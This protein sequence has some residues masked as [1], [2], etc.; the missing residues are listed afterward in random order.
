M[1]TTL[2]HWQPLEVIKCLKKQ[3]WLGSYFTWETQLSW[4]FSCTCFLLNFTKLQHINPLLS[5]CVIWESI[6]WK[7]HWCVIQQAHFKFTKTCSQSLTPKLDLWIEVLVVFLSPR[8]DLFTSNQHPVFSQQQRSREALLWSNSA[9]SL[10]KL[11][12]G[13]NFPSGFYNKSPCSLISSSSG[14]LFFYFPLKRPAG[15]YIVLHLAQRRGIDEK[16]KKSSQGFLNHSAC[17]GGLGESVWEDEMERSRG[18][19]GWRRRRRRMEGYFNEEFLHPWDADHGRR[20]R[21][22]GGEWGRKM[23]GREQDP[24]HPFLSG[25]SFYLCEAVYVCR[26]HICIIR[27]H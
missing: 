2:A 16:W 25:R 21:R 23:R 7:V 18:G 12:K 5:P 6:Y 1:L 4:C 27:R 9:V 26:M 15:F 24:F 20:R 19:G 22:R 13:R 3:Y 10:W 8:S 11:G 14:C 17:M